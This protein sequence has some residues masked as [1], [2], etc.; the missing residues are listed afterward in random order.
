M[1]ILATAMDISMGHLLHHVDRAG[2]TLEMKV[3]YL[4]P[5]TAG[6]VRCEATFLHR[7]RSI[8]FLQSQAYGGDGQASSARNV[9]VE[10]AAGAGR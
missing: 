6:L 8:C 1:E 4:A 9:Y 7:G 3:Q 5:I 2:A 10:T